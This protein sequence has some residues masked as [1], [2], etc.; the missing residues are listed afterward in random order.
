MFN[1]MRE[2]VDII[3]GTAVAGGIARILPEQA[4]KEWMVYGGKSIIVFTR[5]PH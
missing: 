2:V 1:N 5:L 3:T 4:E